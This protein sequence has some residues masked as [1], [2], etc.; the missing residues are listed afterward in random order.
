LP[1]ITQLPSSVG[2]AAGAAIAWSP[3]GGPL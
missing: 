2:E 1:G 3:E